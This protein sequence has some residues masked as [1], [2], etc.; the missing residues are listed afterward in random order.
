MFAL[1]MENS[2]SDVSYLFSI[3]MNSLKSHNYII[4]LALIQQQILNGIRIT[5]VFGTF[6][7][8]AK[9]TF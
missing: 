8:R 5:L 7:L 4:F 1:N 9:V 2:S 6:E 3:V